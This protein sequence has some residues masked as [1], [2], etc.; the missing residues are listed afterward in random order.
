MCIFMDK[1]FHVLVFVSENLVHKILMH[2]GGVATP[3]LLICMKTSMRIF[4]HNNFHA[5]LHVQKLSCVSF[6]Y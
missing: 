2:S 4:M 5:Y 6:L 1:N 3:T